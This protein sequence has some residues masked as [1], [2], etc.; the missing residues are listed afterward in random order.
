LLNFCRSNGL[1]SSV[2]FDQ[3]LPP[4]VDVTQNF[5]QVPLPTRMALD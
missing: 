5:T 1:L 4:L 2:A 3:T